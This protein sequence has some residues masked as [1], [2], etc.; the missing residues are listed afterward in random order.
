M[1]CETVV[2]VNLRGGEKGSKQAR[3][4]LFESMEIQ[5]ERC[6]MQR[7]LNNSNFFLAFFD[8]R[9]VNR[10]LLEDVW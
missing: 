9:C 4:M 1:A 2:R 6:V 7:N 10:D 5:R 8:N 3:G